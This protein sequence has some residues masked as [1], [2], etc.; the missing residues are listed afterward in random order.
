M[1]TRGILLS[2]DLKLLLNNPTY[3]DLKILCEDEVIVYG[4]KA[5]LAARCE[6]LDKLLFN[7]MKETNQSQIK[8]PVIKSTPMLIVMEYLYTG[9]L[10]NNE[11][12]IK[13]A[14]DNVVEAYHASDYFQFSTNSVENIAPELLTNAVRKMT[15]KADNELI[16]LLTSCVAKVPLDTL[17]HDKLSV[18]AL[19]CLL[20]QTFDTKELFVTPEYSI[21]RYVVIRITNNLSKDLDED[22]EDRKKYEEA[23]PLIIENLLP[24]LKFIDLRRIDVNLLIDVI[25]PL[26]LIPVSTLL[27]VYRFQAR[28][29]RSL[30]PT[31]R[32]PLT[33]W[34][35]NWDK[36]CIGSNLVITKDNNNCVVESSKTG[37]NVHNNVRA[38][39]L[40][41]DEG[42]FEW[43]VVVEEICIY[44]WV[45]I[46][47]EKGLDYSIFAGQQT[48][49]WVLGSSGKC[50]HNNTRTNYASE[51][52]SGTRITVHL[53]MTNKTCAFSINGVKYPNVANWTNLPSRVYP[54]ASINQPEQSKKLQ[55]I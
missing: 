14:K 33:K 20:R 25:E 5:I 34:N 30:S 42:I 40:I 55:R 52:S 7:G 43:D 39:F 38:N 11:M 50:Y 29:K 36:Q 9:V 1:T 46:A 51:F 48:C 23:R 3:S 16:R 15:S 54:I 24:L 2:K 53:D 45:G 12:E 10:N 41:C 22:E 49:A 18:E 44:A 21:F 19:K 17:G 4:N 6:V 8:F 37:I 31:R 32:A 28:E 26:N 35:I 27:D 47:T 13:L